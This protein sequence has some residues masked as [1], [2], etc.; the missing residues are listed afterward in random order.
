MPVDQDFSAVHEASPQAPEG[1]GSVTARG[2]SVQWVG[3]RQADDGC[4][5][6][7]FMKIALDRLEHMQE[8]CNDEGD[9]LSDAIAS[10]HQ[11]IQDLEDFENNRTD[12]PEI[13]DGYEG[14]VDPVTPA[15]AAEDDDSLERTVGMDIPSDN[16]TSDSADD[17]SV[18]DSD[19]EVDV[20]DS[21]SPEPADDEE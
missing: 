20:P 11:V 7:T 15:P 6:H 8:T 14:P 17:S 19:S 10:V 12:L 21:V 16:G 9:K 18:S 2:F 4:T 13:P 1:I 3:D 5:I